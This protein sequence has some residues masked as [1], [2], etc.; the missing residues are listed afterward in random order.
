[1]KTF[2]RLSTA[3]FAA[4][5]TFL[6]FAPPA[7]AQFRAGIQGTVTDAAGAVVPGAKVVLTSQETN[8]ARRTTTTDEG[9]Y[10]I[11]GLAPGAYTLSVEKAGF[12]KKVLS[13]VQVAAEQM[14]SIG[15]QLDVGQTSESITVESNVVPLIDT[16]TAMI[17]G[18]LSSKEVERLPSFAR[19]PYQLLRLA[20][21]VFGDGALS[22]GGGSQSLPGTNTGAPSATDS[23]FKV[24]NGAQIVANGT[25]QNSNSFQVDGVPVNSTSWGGA[26][27]ITP[28]EE[29]VKEVR[30][31]ANNYSAENGRN[32]GAQVLV[33]SQNGTNEPHGSAFFKWHRPGLNAY[34]RWNGPGTPTPV[35]KDENR[36]NQFGGSLGG[37][38]VKNKLFAFFS[39]ET[40]RNNSWN[41]G[42]GWY[43]TPQFLQTAGSS[44]SIARKLL[45]YPGEGP[46]YTRQIGMSC[47]QV[48]LPATQ[49]RDASGGLDLGSPLATALGASDPSYGQTGTPYGIGSGFDGV[50]DAMFVQTTS[51]NNNTSQQF[52][53]RMDYNPT[54]SDQ[55]AF[56]IY[57]VPIDTHSYNGPARAANSWNHSSLAQSWTGIYTRTISP[58]LLNEARFGV[59]GWDW[60]EFNS[61]P[62]EPWGLPT[63]NLWSMGSV[64]IQNFGAPGFSIFNQK[65]YTGRDTLTKIHGSHSLKFGADISHSTFLDTAP[66][67]ARPSYDF[68]NL[69]EFANDA[70]YHENSNF[71]PVTGQPTAATKHLRF[72]VLGFFV[73]DDW[74]LRRNLT[75]NLGLRWEYF[76]PLTEENGNISNPIL[77]SGPAALTGLKMHKGGNLFDTSKNNWGPQIGVAWNPGEFMGRDFQNRLVVRGGFGI[78]YNLEQLAITSNGRF[79]PPFMVALDLF[80]SN[81]LYAVN[82]NI[83]SYTGWPSNPAAVQTFD[84]ASGL[85]TSGAPVS[86]TGFPDFM[87]STVTYRYSFD[88]QYDLGHNWM[89]SIGYQGSQS[90]HY[91]IQDNLNLLFYPNVNPRVQSLGWYSNYANAHY[92]ALLTEVQ[93]RFSRNYE[94]DFQYRLSRN[95]DMGSQD[96]FMPMYPWNRASSMGPSDYDVT[97]NFKLWGVW[98]PTFF[99]GAQNWMERL[100]GG[101]TLSAIVNTHSGFPWTPQ[102]CNTSGNV[103]YPNSGFG[104]IFP[105]IYSGGAGSNFSNSTF[106]SANGNFPKGALSYFTVPT[107]PAAGGAP[108]APAASISRNMFRGPRYFGADMQI[109]KAFGLPKMKVL[110]ENARLNLQANIYNIFNKLNL[111]GL[112]TTISND[113]VTSNPQFG[114][115]QNALG[116]R[117]IE[118]QARFAF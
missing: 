96:Y 20:S 33:V 110:G 52:N 92:N 117:I 23:I 45:S 48:G 112:N 97:H 44:S 53:G 3:V 18:A 60:N 61:N 71:D 12:S 39:Y 74:K 43:E 78:G 89:A 2:A 40:L 59:S 98:T 94:I 73:Q 66:W 103:G 57:W 118:L 99:K 111:T 86:L 19:D 116:G 90:R 77:G 25:R 26:A 6:V 31:V 80:G 109:A 13:N 100:A 105:A 54:S 113:G 79:N 108:P 58:S 91:T 82:S 22:N 55:I 49:C 32:S 75:V 64:G 46:S 8:V 107:W 21:G 42:T 67:S 72:N 51:P 4:V 81:I 106:M 35:A 24:E 84:P 41:V 50:P 70:P 68:R 93:R 101:W 38:V 47:A 104:C 88:A 5:F 34:Q 85:P 27:V 63:A 115:A 30:I 9:V 17:G 83:K 16:E 11:T 76:S 114:Q 87:P 36:F 14:Q 7:A 29:S 56:S 1:M 28:N 65:T 69:W 15:L 37:P 62:Q 10:A 102:Y 95:T